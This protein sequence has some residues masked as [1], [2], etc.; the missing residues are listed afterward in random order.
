MKARGPRHKT[1]SEMPWM[2]LPNGAAFD[3]IDF[4]HDLKGWTFKHVARQLGNIARFNGATKSFYSVAQHSVLVSKYVEELGGNHLAQAYG[5]LHDAHE[6][7]VGDVPTPLKRY[8]QR[9]WGNGYDRL[10]AEADRVIYTLF[11]LPVE[12]PDHIVE[13]VKKADMIALVAERFALMPKRYSWSLPPVRAAYLRRISP[14][15]PSEAAQVFSERWQWLRRYIHK[16][17]S[18]TGRKP[19]VKDDATASVP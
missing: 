12:P 6:I 4:K 16:D 18:R 14:M 15:S 2:S 9:Q 5:L 19:R 8:Y 17:W 13:M 7:I 11:E 10:V 1:F 3:L